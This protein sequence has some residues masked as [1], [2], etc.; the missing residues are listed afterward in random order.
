M[1]TSGDPKDKQNDTSIKIFA[2]LTQ[3]SFQ[4]RERAPKKSRYFDQKTRFF[5]QKQGI[6]CI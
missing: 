4:Y 1:P 6:N 5:G 3:Y 2:S